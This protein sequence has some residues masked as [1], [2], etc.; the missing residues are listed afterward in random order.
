MTNRCIKAFLGQWR[1]SGWPL[2]GD[3]GTG[4]RVSVQARRMHNI[5]GE[6]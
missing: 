6:P 4:H 2:M 3:A 5:E 1:R